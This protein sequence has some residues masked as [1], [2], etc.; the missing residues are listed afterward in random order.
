MSFA[1]NTGK[2]MPKAV[3]APMRWHSAGKP[4]CGYCGKLGADALH[5]EQCAEERERMEAVRAP[6]G[7]HH[8]GSRARLKGGA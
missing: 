8:K 6:N 7:G 3:F 1:S 5:I 4:R 2:G